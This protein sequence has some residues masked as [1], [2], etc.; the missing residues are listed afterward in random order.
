MVT[1]AQQKSF[2]SSIW[3]DVVSASNQSGISPFLIAAQSALETAWGTR[4]PQNNYFG[5]KGPGGSLMTTEY[6]NGQAVQVP[7]N[8]AGY[9]S[10]QDSLNHWVSLITG[11]ERYNNVPKAGTPQAQAQALASAGYAT[12]PAYADKLT[13]VMQSIMHLQGGSMSP[14]TQ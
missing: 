13:S 10:F 11:H 7:Q 9:A 14:D 8:F 2:I 1:Q 3:D 4:A 6:V 5:I 12:D